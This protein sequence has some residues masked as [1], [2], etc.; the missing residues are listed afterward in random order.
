MLHAFINL[1]YHILHPNVEWKVRLP[2]GIRAKAA[3]ND[4]NVL[5][6]YLFFGLPITGLALELPEDYSVESAGDALL[7]L[8]SWKAPRRGT[9]ARH[10][11]AQRL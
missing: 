8:R 2:V 6:T 9:G 4:R 10:S 1:C 5:N 3:N 7:D 11:V